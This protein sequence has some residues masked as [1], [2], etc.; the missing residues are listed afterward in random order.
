[1]AALTDI[2]R[3]GR[4]AEGHRPWPRTVVTQRRLE[5]R[6]HSSLSEAR[7]TLL[8]LWGDKDAV[9]LA[10]H[11]GAV[12]PRSPCSRSNVPT[13]SSPRSPR[14]IRRRSG[15][16]APSPTFTAS[17]RSARRMRRPWLDLGF[18]GVTHPLGKAQ[19][20]RG[21]ARALRLSARRGRG[22][23]PDPGR[24]RP[25]RHHRARAFP[26]HRQWRGG[27]AARTAARLCAQGHRRAD[28][29]REHRQGREARLPHLG[30]QHRRLRARLRAGR[31]SRRYRSR[32]RSARSGCAR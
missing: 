17:S 20:A 7:A 19:E 14:C 11:R 10:L 18:W 24:P 23:A 29:G 8:G 21:R 3:T 1:M 30:R 12:M 9:H 16:S 28:G 32:S 2:A 31:R 15:S 6:D 26:L 22:P 5:A 4:K 13:A 27:G 25:C